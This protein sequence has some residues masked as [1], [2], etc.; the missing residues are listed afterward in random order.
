MRIPSRFI[1]D[2]ITRKLLQLFRFKFNSLQLT[3]ESWDAVDNYEFE[4]KKHAVE[5]MANVRCCQSA[6]RNGV[7]HGSDSMGER[8]A[9]T[10][11]GM[12]GGLSN[13]DYEVLHPLDWP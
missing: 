4:I 7:E 12:S 10:R 5:S 6:Y 9:R 11:L 8:I 3:K 13:S 1:P 2:N